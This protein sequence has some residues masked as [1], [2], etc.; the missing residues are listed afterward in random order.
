MLTVITPRDEVKTRVA[1]SKSYTWKQLR[2]DV[3]GTWFD[4]PMIFVSLVL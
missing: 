2:V 4:I 3:D 1:M